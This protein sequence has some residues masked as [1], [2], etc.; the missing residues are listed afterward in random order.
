MHVQDSDQPPAGNEGRSTNHHGEVRAKPVSTHHGVGADSAAADV[1]S[2]PALDDRL[3]SDWAD[4]GGATRV[5]PAT[6]ATSVHA[7][8]P[9]DPEADDKR[10]IRIDREREEEAES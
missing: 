9:N 6:S 2:D 7:S 8:H 4:E 5:G 10:H 3:G 1:T